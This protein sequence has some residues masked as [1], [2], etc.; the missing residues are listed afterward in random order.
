MKTDELI[1][2]LASGARPVQ[3]HALGQRFAAAML[4]AFLSAAVV[5]V[6]GYGVR[7]DLL[8][9]VQLPMGWLKFGFAAALMV[10]AGMAVL[11]LARPGMPTR[12]AL[13]RNLVPLAVLWAVALWALDAAVPGQRAA[14][15]LGTTWRTC[16]FSIGMLSLPGF[17]ALLWAMRQAAPTRLRLAGAGVGLLSGALAAL[18]YALHC[19]EV[20]APFLAVWYVL[21]IAIPTALGA[22]TGPRVL[23]W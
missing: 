12:R 18:A 13:A 20:A 21:G 9:A 8:Q 10:T 7:Q 22:A 2:L 19:P 17:A 3:P 14:L 1:G 11:R 5:V 16:P 6:L 23:R 4:V 15:V